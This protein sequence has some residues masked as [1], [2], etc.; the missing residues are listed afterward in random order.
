MIHDYVTLM[1][2]NM[3][4][5][6][7]VLA[8]FLVKALGTPSAKAYAVPFAAVGLVATITGGHMTFTWPLPGAYNI[9]FGETSILLGVLYLTAAWALSRDLGLGALGTYA[10]VAS[11]LAVLLGLRMLDLGMTQMPALSAGGFILTGVGGLLTALCLARPMRR[12]RRYLAAIA[13]LLAAGVWAFIGLG[14][15][16]MHLKTFADYKP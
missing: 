15:F 10:A 3:A 6:L 13:L 16:W 12:L 2:I 4:A 11:A 5:G 8:V 7:I 14:A 1:L 9:L